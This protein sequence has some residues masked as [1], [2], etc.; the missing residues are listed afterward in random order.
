MSNDSLL[1]LTGNKNKDYD[2]GGEENSTHPDNVPHIQEGVEFV[3]QTKW[4]IFQQNVIKTLSA[5]SHHMLFTVYV[6]L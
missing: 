4:T 6:V 5:V 1:I 2:D 3:L